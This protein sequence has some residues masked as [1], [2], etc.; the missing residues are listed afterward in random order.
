[1]AESSAFRDDKTSTLATHMQ[2]FSQRWLGRIRKEGFTVVSV[3][4]TKY[5]GLKLDAQK[6]LV[7]IFVCSQLSNVSWFRCYHDIVCI[8]VSKLLAVVE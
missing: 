3:M 4:R 6:D 2:N 5:E 8:L 1:M 7:Y